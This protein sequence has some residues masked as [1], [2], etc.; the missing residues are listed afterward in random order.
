MLLLSEKQTTDIQFKAGTEGRN[1][2][3]VKFFQNNQTGEI[4]KCSYM[5]CKELGGGSTP[6][7]PLEKVSFD[8]FK[9]HATEIIQRE[10][11]QF[12]VRDYEIRSELYDE[13]SESQQNKFFREH[14]AVTVSLSSRSKW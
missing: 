5:H 10:F 9:H 14:A 7:G 2:P 3:S 6:T 12:F 11:D 8:E 1:M 13:M 4:I